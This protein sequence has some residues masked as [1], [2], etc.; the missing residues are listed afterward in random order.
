MSIKYG[1]ELINSAILLYGHMNRSLP[2]EPV[3][4]AA[5]S[6]KCA[7]QCIKSAKQ[8]PIKKKLAEFLRSD[9]VVSVIIMKKMSLRMT[10]V[11]TIQI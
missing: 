9:A 6:I 2:V 11:H 1:I 3:Q 8:K 5:P 4:I 7:V 10:K